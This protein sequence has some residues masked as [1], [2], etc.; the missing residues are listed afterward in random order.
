MQRIAFIGT[1]GT[2]AAMGADPFDVLDYTATGVHLSA[3]DLIARSGLNGEIAT[4]DPIEFRSFDSTAVTLDNWMALAALCDDVGSS[5]AYDGIVVGHGT[6]S[7]EETAWCLSLVLGDLAIPVVLTGAMRPFSAYSSDGI[8]NLAAACRVAGSPEAR[9][10]NVLLVMNGEIHAPRDVAK[11][12]TLAVE[13]F[14]AAE[15][16]PL[17]NVAGNMVRF[18]REVLRPGP[19][20]QFSAQDLRRFPR[21]DICYS[22]IG[23]DS[24][25]INAFVAAG[26]SG[27]ISAGFGPGMTTPA[28]LAAL[29]VAAQAGVTVVQS[30]R[31]GAG[32][33]VD[34]QCHRSRGILSAGSL[35]P[36]KARILLGLCLARGDSLDVVKQVFALV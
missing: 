2:L 18:R 31:V 11:T 7:M 15:F 29:T 17:G 33:V 26:A 12:D 8:A 4:I 14:R 16:G 10:T 3:Q 36:Q 19:S 30:S 27:L 28:E 25:A 24:T 32:Y 35:S 9:K 13:A 23:A 6:A 22:H 20:L 1:G 21:V 5:G 34:S